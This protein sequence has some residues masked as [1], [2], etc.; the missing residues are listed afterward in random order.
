MNPDPEFVKYPE[1]PHLNEISEILDSENLQV[2]E[3]LDGGNSQVRTIKGRIF[4]GSRANFL[5]REEHFHFPWFKDFNR[6][7]KSNYSFYN[8]PEHLIVY[9][10]FM[11]PHN[12]TYKREF[13][14]KFFMIDVYDTSQKQFIPYNPARDMLEQIGIEGVLFLESLKEGKLGMEGTR[15]LAL[16]ESR[17]SFYGREGIVIKDYD[18]QRF[19]KF[20]RTSANPTKEGLIDEIK[21]TVMSLKMTEESVVNP[22]PENIESYMEYAT[23]VP[24]HLSLV[25][26]EELKRSG[27]KEI[28]LAE[29]T[30]KV[31]QVLNKI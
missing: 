30:K 24:D 10:E 23:I 18:A 28:S 14:N 27:R 6:W 29:I 1:I 7:A 8:L 3:K 17:Y 26:Y 15:K 19:A 12:L 31:K 2:F 20:W 22:G 11:S 25:V 4:T 13:T 16:D 21:K 5:N 9:G